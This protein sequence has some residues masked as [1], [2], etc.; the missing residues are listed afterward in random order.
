MLRNRFNNLCIDSVE[1]QRKGLVANHC[2]Q[3]APS[4]L[5]SFSV[6]GN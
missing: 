5:W 4:Q 1:V 6:S 2:D 3:D